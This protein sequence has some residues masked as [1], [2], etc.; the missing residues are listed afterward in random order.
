MVFS[1]IPPGGGSFARDTRWPGRYNPLLGCSSRAALVTAK[2]PRRRTPRNFPTGST[3]SA[4]ARARAGGAEQE[5]V[6]VAGFG[7]K[8]A[9]HAELRLQS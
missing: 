9:D 8:F 3:A 6:H 7:I 5:R 4:G 2:I 1:A